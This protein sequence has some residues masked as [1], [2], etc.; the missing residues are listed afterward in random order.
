MVQS[1]GQAYDNVEGVKKM[2]KI[3][4]MILHWVFNSNWNCSVNSQCTG[5]FIKGKNLEV[6]L[7][8]VEW[9]KSSFKKMEN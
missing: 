4:L 2:M 9:N 7:G 6:M 5:L 8:I 3:S 1:T